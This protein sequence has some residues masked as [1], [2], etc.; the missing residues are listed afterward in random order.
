MAIVLP[1]VEFSPTDFSTCLCCS[2]LKALLAGLFMKNHIAQS[3]QPS[4]LHNLW[5]SWPCSGCLKQRSS[6]QRGACSSCI[7]SV[8]I[9]KTHSA[10]AI[11]QRD[12][13]QWAN[14]HLSALLQVPLVPRCTYFMSLPVVRQVVRRDHASVTALS[15][16]WL[17]LALYESSRPVQA[18]N[19]VF[20]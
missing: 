11:S 6:L 7:G 2:G 5:N 9:F 1:P 15:L 17:Y 3:S 14:V 19:M 10:T 18:A 8:A 16:F 12:I 4:T 20:C 13:S